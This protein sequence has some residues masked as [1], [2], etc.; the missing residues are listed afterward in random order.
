M[1]LTLRLDPKRLRR[2]HVGL[3]ERL[4]RRA[5]TQVSVEW[6]ESGEPLPGAVALLFML[7][8]L[9]YGLSPGDEAE[10]TVHDF[11]RLPAAQDAD[12]VLDFTGTAADA[13]A[14]HVRFDG[15]A[16]EAA[17]LA[18]LVQSRTPVVSIAGTSGAVVARGDTGAGARGGP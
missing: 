6:H 3:A 7:E 15:I 14:W 1:K 18:A 16:G 4:A 2:W 17:A 5:G 9:I 10:A 12:R 8:R 11:A 13:N